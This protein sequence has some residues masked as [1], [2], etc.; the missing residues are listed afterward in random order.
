[1]FHKKGFLFMETIIKISLLTLALVIIGGL[2]SMLFAKAP[3]KASE[4]LCRSF[5]AARIKSPDLPTVGK[6]VPNACKTIHKE[7]PGDG[8]PQTKEGAMENIADLSAKC[9]WMWLE[10]ISPEALDKHLIKVWSDPCFV[11]YTFSLKKDIEFSGTELDKHMGKTPYIVRDSSDKCYPLGGGYCQEEP[12]D[13]FTKEVRE[14]QEQK[15]RKQN[16]ECYVAENKKD[17]CLNKGGHC[18]PVCGVDEERYD[19]PEWTCSDSN[20]VCCIEDENYFS[21]IDYITKYKGTGANYIYLGNYNNQDIY[22][23]TFIGITKPQLVEL[24][25]LILPEAE[26]R[27]RTSSIMITNLDS[28]DTV[29]EVQTGAGG[30]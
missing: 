28:V 18:R 14:T 3:E 27:Y 19:H 15:C 9:W 29:C 6:V 13:P 12:V 22:S 21:Y 25:E 2:F 1:M 23:I 26:P 10:G 7:V 16:K 4:S 11:C 17:K 20:Y 8:Y 24:A 5:N 30:Q